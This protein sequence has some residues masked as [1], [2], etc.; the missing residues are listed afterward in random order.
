M[1]QGIHT[2]LI[3][4]DLEHNV[5]EAILFKTLLPMVSIGVCQHFQSAMNAGPIFSSSDKRNC[6]VY[7]VN[8]E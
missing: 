3:D 6:A 1:I 8:S 7:S 4:L 2:T 5:S